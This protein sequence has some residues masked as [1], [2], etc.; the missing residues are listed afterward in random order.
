VHNQPWSEPCGVETTAIALG[1][2]I[3]DARY[4]ATL[5]A[6]LPELFARFSPALVVYL[7]GADPATD[8]LLGDW[9][10]PARGL[11]ERDSLPRRVV[12]LDREEHS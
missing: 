7:A 10:I 9:K 6:T 3:D 4:L 2:E 8:D 11:L 5:H 12:E 1:S